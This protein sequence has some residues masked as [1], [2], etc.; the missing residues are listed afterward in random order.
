MGSTS[1]QARRITQFVCG[2]P[3]RELSRQAHL[4]DTRL[5]SRLWHSLQTAST[6]SQARPIDSEQ[7]VCGTQRLERPCQVHLVGTRIWSRLWHSLQMAST[8]SQVRPIKLFV[9]GTP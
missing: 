8:S 2:T 5:R 7:F 4:L 3:L 1:P 6:S 9:C